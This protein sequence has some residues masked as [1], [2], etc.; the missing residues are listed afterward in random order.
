MSSRADNHAD[1]LR[2]TPGA[3]MLVHQGVILAA[4]PEAVDTVGVPLGR[5]IGVDLCDV[6]IGELRSV[7]VGALDNAGADTT[8]VQTRLAKRLR[9]VELTLR[10][11]PDDKTIVGVRSTQTEHHYSA[12]AQ[13]ELTH[14][15]LTGLANRY[16]LLEQLQERMQARTRAPLAVIGLWVD[17]LPALAQSRGQR[18]VDR[19]IKDVGQRL[20][21]RLRGPDVLGRFEPAGFISVLTSDATVAQ[22]AEIAGRL[23]EEVA[24]PVE[25]DAGLVSFT[26]SVA[27][28]SLTDRK[29]TIETVMTKLDDA[30][31]RL[32]QGPSNK[33]EVLK[34]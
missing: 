1:V 8:T 20:Q 17:D 9:P 31:E 24:F 7:V 23:R 28:G 10:Q 18:I 27:V 32:S 4:N 34:L 29:T 33:T 13:G 25:I 30:A 2:Y 15:Q 14:D 6:V 19:V 21:G 26:A 22:L 5:L 12:L 11:L 3:C 16:H